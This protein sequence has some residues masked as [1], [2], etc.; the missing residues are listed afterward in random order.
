MNNLLFPFNIWF[1]WSKGKKEMIVIIIE[2]RVKKRRMNDIIVVCIRECRAL[3]ARNQNGFEARYLVSITIS[4]AG[5][6]T[7]VIP[8]YIIILS[9]FFVPPAASCYKGVCHFMLAFWMCVVRVFFS[10]VRS[11]A[12]F[13]ALCI[14]TTRRKNCD[15]SKSGTYQRNKSVCYFFPVMFW[16]FLSYVL[17]HLWIFSRWMCLECDCSGFLDSHFIAYDFFFYFV[18]FG[19]WAAARSMEWL[20]YLDG[21]FVGWVCCFFRCWPLFQCVDKC[22]RRIFYPNRQ[23]GHS[24]TLHT[25]HTPRTK[26][27]SSF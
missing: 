21:W 18:R 20:W 26:S 10:F 9:L 6:Q 23:L 11:L 25:S 3:Y 27:S 1:E 12:P 8:H 22:K 7:T 17:S 13:R 19:C 5:T 14:R 16:S 2:K 15:T 4:R 24:Y